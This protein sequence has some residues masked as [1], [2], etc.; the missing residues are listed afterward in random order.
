MQTICYLKPKTLNEAKALLVQHKG[1]CNLVSGGTDVLIRLKKNECAADTL[2]S[3][4]DIAELSYITYDAASGLSIGADTTIAELAA[5]AEIC[6]NC[7]LLAEA[8][9]TVGT[10]SIRRKATLAGNI[11]NAAPSADTAPALL[12]LEALI[13]LES[14][15]GARIVPVG[16]FFTGPGETA[17]SDI[18]LVRE[19]RIPPVPAGSAAAYIKYGRIRGADLAMVGVAALAVVE[20]GTFKDIRIA[21]GAVAPTPVRAYAAEKVLRGKK[22]D[23]DLIAEAARVA[24]SECSPI[25]DVRSTSDYRRKMVVVL[26]EQ[27]IT[28]AMNRIKAEE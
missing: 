18:E 15:D 4:A 27:A 28:Q 7:S 25:D 10:P 12:V 5:S 6:N 3:I 26:V 22:V 20:K 16:D 14:M 13:G 9:G 11:C 2:I 23:P 19:I 17:K 8:A 24:V 21:L 1:H